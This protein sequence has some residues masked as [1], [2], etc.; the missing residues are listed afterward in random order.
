MLTP[1]EAKIWAAQKQFI[2]T[3]QGTPVTDAY[4]GS[5]AHFYLERFVIIEKL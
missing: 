4:P 3:H 1:A 2:K 5:V